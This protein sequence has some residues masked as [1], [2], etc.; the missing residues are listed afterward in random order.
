V[1]V[2][3]TVLAIA[4]EWFEWINTPIDCTPVTD[5][6][7]KCVKRWIELFIVSYDIVTATYK[8]RYLLQLNTENYYNVQFTAGTSIYYTPFKLSYAKQAIV[9]FASEQWVVSR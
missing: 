4:H 7:G 3:T 9:P 5:L 1:F 6:N 8:Y 2:E